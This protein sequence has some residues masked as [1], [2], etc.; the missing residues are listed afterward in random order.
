MKEAK[1][2]KQVKEREMNDKIQV[3]EE[4]QIDNKHEESKKE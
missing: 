3:K 4:R 1:K 2:S